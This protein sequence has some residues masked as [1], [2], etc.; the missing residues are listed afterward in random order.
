MPCLPRATRWVASASLGL[1]GALVLT[2]RVE[3]AELVIACELVPGGGR[4]LLVE[5]ETAVGLTARSIGDG[6]TLIEMDDADPTGWEDGARACR[7]LARVS[8]VRGALMGSGRTRVVVH[9]SDPPRLVASPSRVR[10]LWLPT[11]AAEP[12]ATRQDVAAPA[13][14]QSR[15]AQKTATKAIDTRQPAVPAEPAAPMASAAPPAGPAP[16]SEDRVL[17]PTVMPTSPEATLRAAPRAVPPRLTDIPSAA[18]EGIDPPSRLQASIATD[19]R[20]GPGR[21]HE[22]TRRVTASE[23]VVVDARMGDWARLI[24][25]G[26]VFA[27]YFSTPNSAREEFMATVGID[28]VPVRSGPGEQHDLVAE[29]FRGESVAIDEVNGDWAHVRNGGWILRSSLTP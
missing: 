10:L 1:V 15:R 20:S 12:V 29:I 23:W 16:G 21:R 24:G 9:S 6:S 14:S 18:I 3:A 25:G 5:P 26:W 13:P 22:I 8:V 28:R 7:T 11:R 19:V 17:A 4:S 2:A 27:P